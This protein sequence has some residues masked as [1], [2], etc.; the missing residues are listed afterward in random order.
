MFTPGTL[1]AGKYE[2]LEIAG[3]GGMATVWKARLQDGGFGARTLAIK[4][5]LA[6]LCHDPHFVDLFIEEARVSSQLQHP[7]VVQ[8]LDFGQDSGLYFLAM[9]WVDGLDLLDYARSFTEQGFLMPWAALAT[10]ATEVLKGLELAH[11]HIDERGQPSPIFHRDVTPHNVLIGTNGAVK[12]TDFGLAKATDRGT[13]TL[14]HVLKG[15]ISYTAPE[16]TRGVKANARTDIFSLG[17]TFW[18][19]LAGRKMF[20]AGSPLQIVR[21]IQAWNVPPLVSLRPDLPPELIQVVEMAVA[22]DPDQRYASAQQMGLALARLLPPVP[23]LVR[24]GKSVA[25]ARERHP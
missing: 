8:I 4:V 20:D 11:D 19:A 22:R 9:E 10:V 12:L 25:Q 13:M 2:L 5:M 7:N 6:R 17:V 23:D 1:L 3:Q 14:P 15:K 24:L 18:E 21:Q 16:M